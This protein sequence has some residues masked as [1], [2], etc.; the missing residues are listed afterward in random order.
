MASNYARILANPFGA[1]LCGLPSM[2]GQFTK[3]LRVK[4]R[5]NALSQA[6]NNIC[7]VMMSPRDMVANNSNGVWASVSAGIAATWFDVTI[8]GGV[9]AVSDS[10]YTVAQYNNTTTGISYR[11]VAAGLRIKYAGTNLNKG[12]IIRAIQ[13]Q[14]HD[15]ITGQT[16]TQIGAEDVSSTFTPSSSK[17]TT[18]LYSPVSNSDLNFSTTVPNVA[19]AS[20]ADTFYMGFAIQAAASCTV[21]FEAE[22]VFEV[23]GRNVRGMTYSGVDLPGF[24]A[25]HNATS[26]GSRVRAHQLSGSASEKAAVRNSGR[27]LAVHTSHSQTVENIKTATEIAKNTVDITKQIADTIDIGDDVWDIIDGALSFIFG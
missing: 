20:A 6:T 26:M 8:N 12:G 27:S 16:Q 5:G 23:F 4:I 17:W 25:V 15:P 13:D 24:S 14:S 11:I 18:I 9:P 3:T 10:E 22:C 1:Q 2:P 7:W 21:T 19:A